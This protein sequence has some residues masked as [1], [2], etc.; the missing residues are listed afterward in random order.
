MSFSSHLSDVSS[1]AKELPGA[2]KSF[3]DDKRQG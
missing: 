3:L 1:T 2:G